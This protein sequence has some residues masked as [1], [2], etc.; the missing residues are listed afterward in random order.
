MNTDQG[1]EDFSGIGIPERREPFSAPEGYFRDFNE[2]LRNRMSGSTTRREPWFKPAYALGAAVIVIAAILIL[3]Q[4]RNN[5]PA[6]PGNFYS[7]EME[8][9]LLYTIDE[10]QVADA[11]R[12]MFH[13]A[14]AADSDN[15]LLQELDETT[16]A[17]NL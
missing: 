4:Y 3:P 13:G 10:E 12:L 17:N 7:E 14:P 1:P 6:E 2:R 15:Y 8:N 9:E 16:L 5:H 11:C